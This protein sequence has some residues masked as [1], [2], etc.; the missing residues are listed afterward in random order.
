[1]APSTT[2]KSKTNN[3]NGESLVDNQ[4]PN[5]QYE[6][7]VI[8]L[9]PLNGDTTGRGPGVPHTNL[10]DLSTTIVNQAKSAAA[11]N[12]GPKSSSP[13]RSPAKAVRGRSDR[14][15]ANARQMSPRKSKN[16]LDFDG[17]DSEEDSDGALSQVYNKVE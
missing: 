3:A 17:D 15:P 10:N 14:P 6:Q 9:D 7:D 5:A 11:F 8:S 4:S 13:R 16:Y 2:D 12:E 1:M